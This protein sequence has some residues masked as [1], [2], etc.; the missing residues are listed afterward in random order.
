MAPQL[1]QDLSCVDHSVSDISFSFLRASYC[2]FQ[3][4]RFAVEEINNAT[5]LLPNITLGYQIFDDCTSSIYIKAMFA[6]VL[7]RAQTSSG[8]THNLCGYQPRV[9]AIIG[10]WS[11][12]GAT[13]VANILHPFLLPQ[14]SYG[15]SSEKLSD[16]VYFPSFLRTI[17]SDK[18]QAE[19]IILLIQRFKYD[20]IAVVGSDDQYGQYGKH[21]VTTLASERNICMA[22]QGIIKAKEGTLKE[23][24]IQVIKHI[25]SSR[26]NITVLFATLQLTVMYFQTAIEL[27]IRDKVW[28]ISEAISANNI[29]SEIPNISKVGLILGIAVREGQMPGFQDFLSNALAAQSLSPSNLSQASAESCAQTCIECQSFTNAM[30][31]SI[32]GSNK[33]GIS[34]NVYS[35]VYSVAHS[36]HQLLNCDSG[37]CNK[38]RTFLPSELLESLKRVNFT[39]HNRT[40]NFDANGNLRTGYNII[41]WENKSS[42]DPF[43]VIGSYTPNPGRVVINQPFNTWAPGLKKMPTSKCS[44]ECEPGQ[45]KNL[46]GFHHCCFKCTDCPK[47]TFESNHGL[48]LLISSTSYRLF[49]TLQLMSSP[50]LG[51][52]NP[53]PPIL[54][55]NSFTVYLRWEDGISIALCAMA[56]AGILA[57]ATITVIFIVNL[58]TPIVKAAGGKLCFVMLL[59]LVSGSSCVFAFIGLP[60]ELVCK[61]R[62]PV[63][64]VS[65]TVF[66]S[67]ILVRS[68][69]LACIFKMASRLPKAYAYW[70][71]YNGQYVFVLLSTMVSVFHSL[72]L[73]I[74]H[75]SSFMRRDSLSDL[76][77]ILHCN[78]DLFIV[79]LKSY[80]YNILLSLLCFLFA[81]LGKDLPKN[82]NEGKWISQ[83]MV[84][85][86]FS[87]SLFALISFSA[88]QRYIPIIQAVVI[89]SSSYGIVGMYF[90]PKCYIILFKPQQ[91]TNRPQLTGGRTSRKLN[92]SI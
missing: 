63:F 69:Q 6:F 82:Y 25:D 27:N 64:A 35:A 24:I 83:S 58:K 76:E 59:A 56:G 40:I 75:P 54:A 20:W 48:C 47:N 88:S 85:F 9:T 7:R 41:I 8:A 13:I 33:W 73:L 36:L 52:G 42:I 90:I 49:R 50:A 10:P 51:S 74:N 77:L 70:I 92:C 15:A 44:S 12:D 55:F 91:N 80:I 31:Q 29:L 57:K 3:A 17:P 87:W 89:L 2:I 34:F 45:R 22:Y 43:R 61:V 68:F 62:Q 39:L 78:S 23:A 14:I 26:V 28:I 84:V 32:L 38:S 4:M 21:E 65:F 19:A 5:H 53:N 66:L 60:S 16:K 11:S 79:F 81:F 1:V 72:M 71:K 18:N 37:T 30:V 67:C 46:D 86:I